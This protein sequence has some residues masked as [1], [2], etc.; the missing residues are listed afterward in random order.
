MNIVL[1][2][3]FRTECGARPDLPPRLDATELILTGTLIVNGEVSIKLSNHSNI[4]ATYACVI[5]YWLLKVL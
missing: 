5:V 2:H 1:Q 3:N 4:D